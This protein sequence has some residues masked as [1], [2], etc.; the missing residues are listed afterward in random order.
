MDYIP[1]LGRLKSA[2]SEHIVANGEEIAVGNGTVVS[3][4]ATKE[5][6][7][8][9]IT[10]RPTDNA[11]KKNT[12][13]I[14][15]EIS[16]ETFSPIIENGEKRD[17]MFYISFVVG[18]NAIIRFPNNCMGLDYFWPESGQFAEMIAIWNVALNKWVFAYQ[19]VSI[20]E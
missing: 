5:N 13:Y 8:D 6:V 19:V 7:L 14:L 4:L 2:T 10:T 17:D 16:S 18:D 1:V 9:I 12:M 3:A 15:G 20:P 11:Y